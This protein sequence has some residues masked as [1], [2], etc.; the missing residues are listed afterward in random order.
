MTS[1]ISD[2]ARSRMNEIYETK[3]R[4]GKGIDEIYPDGKEALELFTESTKSF[5]FFVWKYC[6]EISSLHTPCPFITRGEQGA[7][8]DNG[9]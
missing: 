2:A 9:F 5:S 6:C 1:N 8:A 4:S 7:P 3:L